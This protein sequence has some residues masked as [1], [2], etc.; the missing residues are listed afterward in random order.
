[1]VRRVFSRFGIRARLVALTIVLIGM[2]GAVSGFYLEEE[3][4]S[5]LEQRVEVELVRHA[6][7]YRAALGLG[8][9]DPQK[10]ATELGKPA[11]VRFTLIDPSGRVLADSDVDAQDVASL[12]NHKDRPEV[13]AALKGETTFARRAS[14]TVNVRL[15]YVAVPDDD[16]RVVR[17]ALPLSR[18]DQA[19][20]QV[21]LVL[22]I[23]GLLALLVA[24]IVGGVASHLSTLTLR[25]MVMRA[26]AMGV[27]DAE[28]HPTGDELDFLMGSFES[29]ADELRR[30]LKSLAKARDRFEV[31]V[32]GMDQAVFRLNGKKQIKLANHAAL[33]LLGL[34]EA[35]LG[36]KV[37][38]LLPDIAHVVEGEEESDELELPG[39]KLVL[40]QHSRMRVSRGSVLVLY[41]VSHLRKLER[42]RKDFVANVSHELRTP[43]SVIRA[44]TEALLDDG[45]ISEEQRRHFLQALHRASVRLSRL[46]ADL[47]DLARI[48]SGAFAPE[49]QTV[50]LADVIGATADAVMPRI[51]EREH[52][53][54]LELEE[55]LS[56]R[57]DAGALEQVLINLL[58]NA[59]KYT[60][61][62]GH[63]WLRAKRAGD[64]VRI[65]IADDGPGIA[66]QHRARLFERFY[67]VDPGRSREMGGTGLGLSIVKHLIHAM[68]G[69]VGMEPNDPKGAVF[70]VE[71][72]AAAEGQRAAAA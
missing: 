41:D 13:A 61:P 4:R 32:E 40:A 29:M 72:Q 43:I 6:R 21:R 49:T 30:A 59:A 62:R 2:A 64:R 17:A 48:E 7:T 42:V 70:F 24:L 63:L 53:V 47:L 19:I 11:G 8:E 51:E 22:L 36:V 14:S 18:I 52:E 33:E 23:A 39:G 16:G 67:R 3:L 54:S 60:P 56:V 5:V 31:V 35:P 50:R 46:F 69:E 65:E 57:A 68:E 25:R 71:L 1:M 28:D 58:D 26:R 15:L 38:E 37:T 55:G 27:E 20:A 9:S 10:V 12:D 66:E 44:N 45:E 34:E